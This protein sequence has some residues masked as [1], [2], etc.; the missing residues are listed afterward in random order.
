[1]FWAERERMGSASVVEAEGAARSMELARLLDALGTVQAQGSRLVLV[2]APHGAGKTRLLQALRRQQLLGGG[3]V[4][5][6]WCAPSPPFGAVARIVQ[7][8]IRWL[9]EAG[10]PFA[11]PEALRC[12][13]GCHGLWFEHGGELASHA[14]FEG[15]GRP[16]SVS[17]EAFLDAA[18]EPLR[19]LGRTRT[20]LLLLHELDRAD[21]ATLDWLARLIEP[22]PPW[23]PEARAPRLLAVASAGSTDPLAG[24]LE[25]LQ[26]SGRL[27]HLPLAPLGLDGVRALLQSP[28]LAR[29]VLERTGGHVESI[30]RLLE[31]PPPPPEVHW[32]RALEAL[33]DATRELL[34]SIALLG[35]PVEP[36][37]LAALLE[38]GPCSGDLPALLERLEEDGWLLR[39]GNAAW[40]L[41]REGGRERLLAALSEPRRRRL[42]ARW[43]QALLEREHGRAEAVEHALRAARIDLALQHAQ[44]AAE[45]LFA[46]H[47]DR[48]AVELLARVVGAAGEDAPG[49]LREAVVGMAL[50]AA[51][52]EPAL[53]VA[54]Q[55]LQQEPHPDLALRLGRLFR[56][57]DRLGEAEQALRHASG[58]SAPRSLRLAA[59]AERAAVAFERDAHEEAERLARQ[60]LDRAE[61]E[62][63]EHDTLLSARNTLGKLS[64][65]RGEEHD[66]EEAFRHNLQAAEAAG[67]PQRV[68]HARI[69]LA[70]VAIRRRRL[71]EAEHALRL[72]LREARESGA[73]REEVFALA[74]L[75]ITAM[76]QRRFDEALD[77]YRAAMDRL[78]AMGLKTLLARASVSLGELYLS[79][80]DAKRAHALAEFAG[81][82]G[83]TQWSPWARVE[84]LLLQGRCALA[85]GE[86]RAAAASFELAW[87]LASDQE[88]S[89]RFHAVAGCVRAALLQGKT[90]LAL[91]WFSRIPERLAADERAEHALLC[92]EVERARLGGERLRSTVQRAV[93]LAEEAGDPLRS[94]RAWSML[95][96]VALDGDQPEQARAAYEQAL[97]LERRLSERV[98]VEF[99][100]AWSRR[101]A[102][103]LLDELAD[104]LVHSCPH[105]TTPP[106][107]VVEPSGAHRIQTLRLRFPM[108]V[109]ASEAMRQILERID[110]V[111][112]TDTLVMVRGESGTGKELVAEAL[113]QASRRARGPLVKVNCAALVETLLLSELFGHEKGAFTG[114]TS[115]RRGRFELADGGT[116]F[117]DEIGDITPKTQVALLRVLQERTF[118]RVGGTQP[119]SV[120]VR[121]VAATNRDLERL[122][123]EGTF[124]EDLYYRLRCV[125][126]ELPPLRERREDVPELAAHLLERLAREQGIPRR[127]LSAAAA[128][129]LQ[130]HHWPGNVRE[131]ENVLRAAALFADR[132]LLRPEDVEPFLEPPPPRA[133]TPPPPL[134]QPEPTSAPS[135]PSEDSAAPRETLETALYER[136]RDS[137]RSWLEW[138]KELERACV[139][140]ALRE[141][142][143]NI[144]RAAKLLGMKRPRL[145]QLVKEYDLGSLKREVRP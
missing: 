45:A 84:Q 74:N 133:S 22:P 33:P 51:S 145:S 87:Q 43:A 80:G 95:A 62:P 69:N 129:R 58:P 4:L 30:E 116:L 140:H 11:P 25:A 42:H 134:E 47:A 1:M 56:M 67:L 127:R 9:R 66:A 91:Q 19:A 119:L 77:R 49:H 83:G 104:R 64:L 39:S 60:V 20:P 44:E 54:R 141:A 89:R 63:H 34:Q 81:Q 108:F 113:H 85:E 135:M 10:E 132:V 105:R 98:P 130:H 118:E 101:P 61:E 90:S 27:E 122:V 136:V 82:V 68:A 99:A 17:R 126:I 117:L 12:R 24:W 8:A 55:L 15:S 36:E 124:R 18:L 137:G 92:V 41:A 28:R 21:T 93:T 75:A 13:G 120:D 106:P 94:L 65:A 31:A 115:R 110:R 16:T 139:A 100:E 76:R 32:A 7:E 70:V 123:A 53:P 102:R 52:P 79:L 46:R 109:G 35:R 40:C 143:G 71:E 14:D 111:A 73:A 128:T 107:P 59:L 97:Q 131:L 125:T 6:A 144:T 138:K 142:G 72:A 86:A 78:R 5:E 29:R 48:E 3:L 50:R 121:I 38:G 2:E 103:R 96:R 88:T 114:A 37:E 26:A 57:A 23:A 112:A